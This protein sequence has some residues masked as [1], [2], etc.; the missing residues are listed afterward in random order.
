MKLRPVWVRLGRRAGVAAVVL[1][2]VA[3][4]WLGPKAVAQVSTTHITAY[5]PTTTGLYPQDDVRILGVRVGHID[6]IRPGPD[7]VV[8]TMSIDHGVRVPADARAVTVAPSVVSARFV[9]LAPAYTGGP[10]LRNHGEIPVE[11]TAVPMEWED[12]KAALAKLA[13]A[14]GPT[15]TDPQGSFGRFVDTGAANL[16]GGNAA[17]LRDT[18]RELSHALGTL[19]DGRDDLFTTITNLQQFVDVLSHSNDQIVQFQGRLASVSS[20]LAGVAPSLGAGLDDLDSAVVDVRRFLD[21][22]GGQLTESVRR[23]AD[24]TQLLADKRDDLERVLHSGPTALVN[25]YQIYKPAQGTLTGAVAGVNFANP[26]AFLCG[27]IEG[28]QA[29][30]SDRSAA[31]CRQYV[32]PVLQSLM[33]NYPPLLVNPASGQGAFPNQL[34]FSTPELADRLPPAVTVP[35]SLAGLALPGV[36]P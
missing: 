2:V 11:R 20:V 18:L 7:H 29:N 9:Q 33:M 25:F 6:A 15:A 13:Q 34:T 19:S 16:A 31:L 32:A 23:L 28:L 12:I 27:A 4:A 36:G 22:N 21:A 17:A 5:F 3:G 14:L 35:N 8:V 24:V 1:L 30:D 10:V 26:F